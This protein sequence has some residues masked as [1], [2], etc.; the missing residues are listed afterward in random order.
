M[1]TLGTIRRGAGRSSPSGTTRRSAASQR[2]FAA[3]VRSARPRGDERLPCSKPCADTHPTRSVESRAAAQS[4]MRKRGGQL[5]P[6]IRYDTTPQPPNTHHVATEAALARVRGEPLV[7]GTNGRVPVTLAVL[8]WHSLYSA[9]PVG[10]APGRRHRPPPLV[11][12]RARLILAVRLRSARPS[13]FG[14]TAAGGNRESH[15]FR[16]LLT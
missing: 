4:R 14:P 16:Q 11:R 12:F 8:T 7:T 13:A 5:A 3:A 2:M 1:G 15:L 10:A 6:L 9:T